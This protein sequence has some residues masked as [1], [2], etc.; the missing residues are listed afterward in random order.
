MLMAALD[1]TPPELVGWMPAHLTKK[2]LGQATKSDGSCVTSVDLAANDRAD[3]LA[4][5][6]V[7]FHRVLSSDVDRWVDLGERVK[8]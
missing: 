4:K 1:G 6:G 7:E 2:E 8:S 3:A 5:K